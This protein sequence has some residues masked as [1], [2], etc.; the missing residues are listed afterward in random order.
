MFF[1]PKPPPE[2]L[3]FEDGTKTLILTRT[4]PDAAAAIVDGVLKSLPELKSF[5]AWAHFKDNNTVAFQIE[6]L[7]N[8][9][10]EWDANRDFG[11]TVLHPDAEG[12]LSFAGCIGLH[13]RPLN[14]LGFE[15]GYWTHT[16]FAGR[17]LCTLA[18]QMLILAAFSVMGLERVAVGCDDAN[19]GSR[20][21]IEKVGY[22]YEGL[23]R[24]DLPSVPPEV[25]ADG[26]QGTGD[27]RSY[28]LIAEDL[29]TLDWVAHVRAHTRHG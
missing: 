15:I 1:S 12:A 5:M 28:G 17:G 24:K 23:K 14:P 20:G 26:W 21:V 11:W 13:P 19:M 18:N 29:E 3:T 8:L 25:A 10:A 27:A 4:R 9:E 16:Q 6:R 22:R 2:I 7:K